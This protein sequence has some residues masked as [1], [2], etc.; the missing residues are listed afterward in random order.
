MDRA[1]PSPVWSRPGKRAQG[2]QEV[3]DGGRTRSQDRLAGG[4]GATQGQTPGGGER[5]LGPSLHVQG[6][7][8]EQAGVV[9]V[10]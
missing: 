4:P 6:P 3:A 1:G 8:G 9:F 2:R 5:P 7:D 10:L